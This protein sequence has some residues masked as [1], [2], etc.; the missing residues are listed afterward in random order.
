MARRTSLTLAAGLLLG[1]VAVGVIWGLLVG[2]ATL[3]AV[4]LAAGLAGHLVLGGRA[5]PELILVAGGVGAVFAL[6]LVAFTGVPALIRIGGVPVVWAAAG[7]IVVLA[8]LRTSPTGR[9]H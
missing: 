7:A 6:A 1:L 9:P 4:I 3:V 2:V 5:D 8:A